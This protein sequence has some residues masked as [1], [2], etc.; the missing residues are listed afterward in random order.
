MPSACPSGPNGSK[1]HAAVAD[2]A[3]LARLSGGHLDHAG[4][5]FGG[6]AH[7]RGVDLI[8][9]RFV[10]FEQAV[11]RIFRHAEALVDRLPRDMDTDQPI[12][13]KYSE[14]NGGTVRINERMKVHHRSP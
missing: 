8:T 3:D 2:P 11:L 14:F 10:G 7:H 9:M 12:G 6:A 5:T 1:E 4:A 13:P